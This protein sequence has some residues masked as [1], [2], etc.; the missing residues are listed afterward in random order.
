MPY[1]RY[2]P[3]PPLSHFVELFWYYEGEAGRSHKKERLL[4]QGSSELVINLREDEMRIYDRYSLSP[5]EKLSGSAICGPHSR[6]FVIDTAEQ[7]CVAGAHFK[8][9]GAFPFFKAPFSE[10]H[11]QHISLDVLWGRAAIRLR[12]RLLEEST[13]EAKLRRFEQVL[14]E[15]IYRP[16][17]QHR[18]VNYALARLGSG[19]TAIADL[20]SE[21]GLSTRR[22]TDLFNQQVGVTPK[23]FSRVQRFQNVVQSLPSEHDIDWAEVALGCGYYDQA[24]FIH[25]FRDFSGLSPSTYMK[26]RTVHANHVPI[27]ED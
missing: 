22:L 2:R 7:D 16:L 13:P 25:D 23:L 21:I 14:L 27:F 26:L 18:A 19:S 6:F 1:L 12:D 4:P 17:E 3:S 20:S 15:Q 11:N 8:P 10:F 9:G 5:T 24:H